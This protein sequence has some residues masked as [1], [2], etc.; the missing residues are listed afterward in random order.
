[1]SSDSL[2]RFF[3]AGRPGVCISNARLAFGFALGKIGLS[4]RCC[5]VVRRS[6]E[7]RFGRG[8]SESATS[9][10][11]GDSADRVSLV[12]LSICVCCWMALWSKISKSDPRDGKC[13][14]L[15]LAGLPICVKSRCVLPSLR[16]NG[17]DL[18]MISEKPNVGL[19][20]RARAM[21]GDKYWS[22]R[23][24]ELLRLS[25]NKSD[26]GVGLGDTSFSAPEAE[27]REDWGVALPLSVN[28]DSGRLAGLRGTSNPKLPRIGLNRRIGGLGFFALSGKTEASG[29][30]ARRFSSVGRL[31]DT[32]RG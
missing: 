9:A 7:A 13:R 30:D 26:A 29:E 21:F 12:D 4:C 20:L 11:V 10:R 28:S 6:D 2:G 14:L 8:V 5:S 24:A 17:L 32:D 31:T 23:S 27:L 3:E 22:Y 16:F 25:F 18:A 19:S 15:R 1:M